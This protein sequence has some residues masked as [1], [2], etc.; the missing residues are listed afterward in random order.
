M[1]RV[2]KRYKL[3]Y[4]KSFLQLPTTLNF[5]IKNMKNRSL[6]QILVLSGS[7][8]LL[9]ACEKEVMIKHNDKESNVVIEA[10]FNADSAVNIVK[11]SRTISVTDDNRFPSVNTAKVYI[12]DNLQYSE[13]LVQAGDGIYKTN[14]FA[15]KAG[16]DYKLTVQYSGKTYHAN[17]VAP[18]P[19]KLDT[20]II[21]KLK[22]GA[23]EVIGVLPL[24]R[25][26]AGT[27]N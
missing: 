15:G 7:I 25:D 17:C 3:H 24:F 20:L 23:Q 11:I 5:K 13:E 6:K 27:D 8:F 10:N 9:S 18:H 16:L 21:N 26:P 4:S 2:H 19:V 22:M 14:R 12:T 1:Q